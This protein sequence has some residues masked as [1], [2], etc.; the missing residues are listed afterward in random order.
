VEQVIVVGEGK[1]FPAALIVPSFD[2]L[3]TWCKK[4]NIEYTTDADMIQNQKIVDRI[5]K[6]VEKLCQRFGK[7]EQIKKVTLLPEMWTIEGD[8]LTPT[9]KLKR[10]EIHRKY[11]TQIEALYA[12]Q[13]E[14]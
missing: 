10:K 1:N 14:G 12:N 13:S 7:W 6:D 8:E 9:L 4:H 3:K 2:A 11:A 5:W